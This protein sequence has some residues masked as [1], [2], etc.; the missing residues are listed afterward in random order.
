MTAEKQV[1]AAV[2]WSNYYQLL[3]AIKQKLHNYNIATTNP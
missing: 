1:F 2:I 3:I